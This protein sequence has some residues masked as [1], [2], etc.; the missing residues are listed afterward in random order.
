MKIKRLICIIAIIAILSLTSLN[1]ANAEISEIDAFWDL[2]RLKDSGAH[3][4][5]TFDDNNTA[6]WAGVGQNFSNSAGASRYITQSGFIIG[7][8]GSPIANLQGI[9]FNKDTHEVLEYSQNLIDT[10]T[11]SGYNWLNFTFYGDLEIVD[12]G[13]FTT[14]FMAINATL[15]DSSNYVAFQWDAGAGVPLHAQD[16][17]YLQNNDWLTV[18][19][20]D[21][22]FFVY[23]S[24]ESTSPPVTPTPTPG[25]GGIEQVI[26][27]VLPAITPMF[28]IFAVAIMGALMAKAWGFFFGFNAGLVISYLTGLIPLWT[29][30]L[31]IVVDILLFYGR[32]KLTSAKGAI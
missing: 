20:W 12:A 26:N 16:M 11:I 22:N 32:L 24:N 8:V 14:G 13:T 9:I 10:S 31:I 4:L 19:T 21:L 29:F 2:G 18:S 25:P 1:V 27:S 23:G 6:S 17:F 15:L 30:V 5:T 7:K 3:I 28:V